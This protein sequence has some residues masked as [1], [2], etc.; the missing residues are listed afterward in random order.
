MTKKFPSFTTSAKNSES[1]V[2]AVST[3]INDGFGWIFRRNHN[4]HDFGIDGHIDIVT[5]D[6]GV[7]GQSI[8]VQIKSGPS[9]FKTETPASYTFY[10]ETKHLNYYINSAVPVVLI[11]H[12]PNLNTSYWTLFEPQKTEKTESGWKIAIP[13][14][15]SLGTETKAEFIR[16]VGPAVD[17]SAAIEAHWAFN[18][19]LGQFE[20]IHYAVDRKHVESK[21]TTHIGEF[22]ERIQSNEGL[23]RKFQGK[24][25][26]S[27][28]G[29]HN[30][31][32]ELWEIS[33]VIKWFKVADPVVKYWFFFCDARPTA[34]GLKTYFLCQCK[35]KRIPTQNRGGRKVNVDIETKLMIELFDRNWPRLNEMTNSLGMSIENNKRISYEIMDLLHVPHDA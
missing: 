24:I 7:T 31:R 25:E 19:F 12:E 18:E 10:G 16:I 29:Y 5:D 3:T 9:Y 6:G 17:H 32:R 1:G 14:N 8:A 33:E 21:N 35:T 4:E 23:C 27:I 30:D 15:N 28:S 22:F 26:L 34:H 13:K 20:N 11:I 2:N